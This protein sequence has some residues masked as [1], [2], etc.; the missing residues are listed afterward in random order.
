[1]CWQRV[2]TLRY[3][4]DVDDVFFNPWRQS[5]GPSRSWTRSII[6]PYFSDIYYSMDFPTRPAKTRSKKQNL[7]E[8]NGKTSKTENTKRMDDPFDEWVVEIR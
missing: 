8:Q 6:L 4:D 3:V 5:D 7:V 1:M 2:S